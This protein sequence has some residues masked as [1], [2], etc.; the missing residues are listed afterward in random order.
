M[1][2][3]ALAAL[4]AGCATPPKE[5]AQL[6]CDQLKAEI[7]AT[8]QGRQLALEKQED[9]FKYV[10]PF[11]VAGVHV[12]AKSAVD[13]ADRWLARLREESRSKRCARQA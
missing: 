13:D 12:A 6:S 9:G 7:R 4:A 2:L 11:A 8:E 10:I 5:P 3:L 1:P